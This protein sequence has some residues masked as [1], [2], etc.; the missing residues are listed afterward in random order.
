MRLGA[1]YSCRGNWFG[2]AA[3][4]VSQGAMSALLRAVELSSCDG[5]VKYTG[6]LPKE[7]VASPLNNNVVTF[8]FVFMLNKQVFM[9]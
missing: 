5:K 8:C 2:L 6:F 4:N 1:S 7:T 3:A 9:S